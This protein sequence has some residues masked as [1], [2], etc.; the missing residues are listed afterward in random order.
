MVSGCEDAELA[1]PGNS[2][3]FSPGE[4]KGSIVWAI[5]Y[6]ENNVGQLPENLQ[7]TNTTLGSIDVVDTNPD[8]EKIGRASCRE[9]CRSRWS[10]Y[11]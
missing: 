4:P 1:F 10:P 8:D 6:D 5:L 2:L 9:K 3:G 7:G 11:H